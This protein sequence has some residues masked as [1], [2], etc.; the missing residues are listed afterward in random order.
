MIDLSTLDARKQLAA[1]YAL[2]Y[3]LDTALVC[4]VIDHETGGTWDPYTTRNEDGFFEHY[5]VNPDGTYKITIPPDSIRSHSTEARTR[6]MSFGLMQVIGETA[7]ENGL[8]PR[9]ITSLCDP[10]IG[11]DMGCKIL[12]AK[13]KAAGGDIA[14]GLALYNGG[15]DPTYAP[16]VMLLV[17][18]YEDPTAEV[19]A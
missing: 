8:S 4:S 12:S 10:D 18:K 16:A 11:V 19:N 5:I 7:R 13:I 6:A 17:G 14:K 2:K 15:S 1:K 9:Y 3:S